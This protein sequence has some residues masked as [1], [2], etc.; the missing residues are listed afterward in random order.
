MRIRRVTYAVR[1]R[2]I[3]LSGQAA[4]A[5]AEDKGKSL[6][7]NEAGQLDTG[8]LPAT[9]QVNS[10]ESMDSLT[11]QITVLSV[12]EELWADVPPSDM[13]GT[14][15]PAGPGPDLDKKIR[16]LKKKIRLATQQKGDQQDVKPEQLEKLVKVEGW[17]EELKLLE[18]KRAAVGP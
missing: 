15:S 1:S 14:L 5:S 2:W 7:S 4:L 8:R 3:D 13:Q 17:R 16:A 10:T 6:D 12:S 9:E 18:E 11:N